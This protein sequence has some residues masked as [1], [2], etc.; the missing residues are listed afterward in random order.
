VRARA[1]THTLTHYQSK[2]LAVDVNIGLHMRMHRQRESERERQVCEWSVFHE[3]RCKH[4]KQFKF[5]EQATI[6]HNNKTHGECH[7]HSRQGAVHMYASRQRTRA[8]EP[9]D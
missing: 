2:S 9:L 7:T 5:A 1:H 6:N 3:L 8:R 4:V